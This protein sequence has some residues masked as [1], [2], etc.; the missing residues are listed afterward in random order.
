[1]FEDILKIIT[2]SK[3]DEEKAFS[4]INSFKKN[5]TIPIKTLNIESIKSDIKIGVKISSLNSL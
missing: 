2:P 3:E 5:K 1:M 4:I